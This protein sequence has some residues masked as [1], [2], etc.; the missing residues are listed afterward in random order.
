VAAWGGSW[1]PPVAGSL[2]LFFFF[3][4]SLEKLSVVGS[5]WASGLLFGC[6]IE[7]FIFILSLGQGIPLNFQPI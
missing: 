7:C 3:F 4:G 5:V 1:P 2:S 6:L